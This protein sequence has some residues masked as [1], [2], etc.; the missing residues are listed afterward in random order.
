MTYT[1]PQPSDFPLP[2]DGHAADA[3][4][5]K[6][7]VLDPLDACPYPY[8]ALYELGHPREQVWTYYGFGG[9]VRLTELQALALLEM[10]ADMRG[11]WREFGLTKS[12]TEKGAGS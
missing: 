4:I 3:R 6:M 10:V 5:W 2:W 11:L 1:P 9:G 7:P 8:L 12:D